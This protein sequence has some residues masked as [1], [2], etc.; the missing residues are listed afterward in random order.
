MLLTGR[1]KAEAKVLFT[2]MSQEELT[3]LAHTVT[4][5]QIDVRTFDGEYGWHDTVQLHRLSQF[6]ACH[7]TVC[8]C[9]EIYP[10]IHWLSACAI[11]LN[12]HLI[13]H[14]LC[15]TSLFSVI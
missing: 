8:F 6:R 14:Y 13:D 15:S 2:F 4:N 9:L 12:F 5:H 3:S 11:L 1:A 7:N 10:A